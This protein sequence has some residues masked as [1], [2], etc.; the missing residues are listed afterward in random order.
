E[1]LSRLEDSGPA[2]ARRIP[3]RTDAGESR[4]A[5]GQRALWF[6]ERLAPGHGANH[7]V[8]AA[9]VRSGLDPAALRRA[10]AGLVERHPAL[11]AT[12][13]EAGGEPV[14]RVHERPD[15]ELLER[16]A[17][18][19]SAGE[20]DE[21]LAETAYRPFD[22]ARGPLLRVALF[23]LG[24]PGCEAVLLLAIHH[25]VADF[26]S[27]GVLARELGLLYAAERAGQPAV[28][29]PLPLDFRDH[30]AWQEELLA[31]VEGTRL[32]G[33]WLERLGGEL[34]QLDLPLDR[35]RP[36]VQTYRGGSTVE[37][38][39]PGAL[40]GLRRFSREHEATLYTSL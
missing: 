11:R 24:Q 23:A 38:L 28:L 10:L 3:R 7:I 14:L 15:F 26:W 21:Q 40:A 20:L 39:G 1:I 37:R 2:A 12:F 30:T 33:Y 4:P 34:P 17:A 36:P 5:A 35:P 22:L 13:A 27:L 6:L 8:A 18:G 29:A 16:D 32:W 9:R 19:W 31:G 25:V